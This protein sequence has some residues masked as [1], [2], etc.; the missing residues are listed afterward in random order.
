MKINNT[1]KLIIAVVISEL[2]G[3]VGSVFTTPSVA[4]PSASG[5]SWYS[6]LAKPTLNPPSWVFA[7]AWT[8]LFALM[9]I[10]AFLIWKKGLDRKD[11]K[12]A[13]S[14]FIGQL[15]LNAF[16]SIIFFGLHSPSSAFIEIIF[17]WLAI[18][19]TIIAFAKISRLAA[20]LLI[21]YL[22]WVSFAGYL[23]YSIWQ[24]NSIQ[25]TEFILCTQEA[26]L[27]QDGSYVGRTG[28]KC[29]FAAC[30]N[31][32]NSNNLWNTTTDSKTGVTFKYPEKLSAQYIS[33]QEW[34]P[35][36]KIQS[37]IYSCAETPQ[38]KSSLMEIITQRIIDNRTYCIDV[39]NEGAAGSVYSSYVYTTPKNGKLI[40]I[41]FT[42]R[43]PNCANY[44][45][46]QGQACTSE[47]E[48]FDLDTMVDRIAQTV[49]WDLSSTN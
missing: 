20:W 12:I 40:E 8:I 18:L 6:G 29:G 47:R 42:L 30:P 9:G 45:K 48:A 32:D 37:G 39:K 33:A 34:P 36:V 23:N 11:I 19:A 4:T 14:I 41:S 46:K 24:L 28:P 31:G 7:P 13:L 26:K 3:I 5:L 22:L 16:W 21:P 44:E 1:F 15:T 17:L 27:C 49:E 2:V 38:E 43:Y 25:R 10:S 35:V